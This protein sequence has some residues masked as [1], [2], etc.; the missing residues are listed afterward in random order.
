MRNRKNKTVE[1]RITAD[2]FSPARASIRADIE[3]RRIVPATMA[4]AAISAPFIG[5]RRMCKAR[6]RERK[7]AI[8]AF[9]GRKTIQM[10]SQSN[11]IIAHPSGAM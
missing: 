10:K 2:L 3:S 5:P 11:R 7:P 8:F 4:S 1:H 6:A 9:S